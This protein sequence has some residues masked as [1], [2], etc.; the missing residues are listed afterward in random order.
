MSRGEILHDVWTRY[1]R[2]PPVPMASASIPVTVGLFAD[3]FETGDTTAWST[4]AP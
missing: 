2:A 4:T 1:D 3:G